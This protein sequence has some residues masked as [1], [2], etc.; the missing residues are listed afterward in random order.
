MWPKLA[1]IQ[2]LCTIATPFNGSHIFI[3][4]YPRAHVS[5]PYI[6]T[7]VNLTLMQLLSTTV[8]N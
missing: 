4:P 7:Y 8:L 1:S 6:V 5:P 3:N 2:V